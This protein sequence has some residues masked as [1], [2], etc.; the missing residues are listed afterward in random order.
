MVV[1]DWCCWWS[2]CWPESSQTL[3]LAWQGVE[4]RGDR[5][6]KKQAERLAEQKLRCCC[7]RVEMCVSL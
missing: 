7:R 5:H 6:G 1:G 4:P 2:C 3:S